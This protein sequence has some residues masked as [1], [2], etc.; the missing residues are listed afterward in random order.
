MKTEEKIIETVF[1]FSRMFREIMMRSCKIN[2]LTTIQLHVLIMIKDSQEVKVKDIAERLM[3][4]MPTTTT[5]IDKLVKQKLVARK[6]DKNDRRNVL[7]CSTSKGKKLLEK[8]LIVRN[9][10]MHK[11]LSN[12]TVLEKDSFLKILN[13]LKTPYEK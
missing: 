9:E 13:K 4:T 8:G 1:E 3:V 12:L 7:I 11:L 6:V 2:C 10:M 5:I